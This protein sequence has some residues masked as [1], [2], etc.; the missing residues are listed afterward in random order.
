LSPLFDEIFIILAMYDSFTIQRVY[1]ERNEE[2]LFSKEGLHMDFGTW[3]ITE[4]NEGCEHS[5]FH[6]LFI[7]PSGRLEA[8]FVT[9]TFFGFEMFR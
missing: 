6:S 1:R 4:V 9:Q 3:L 8:F 5:F 7:D 2:N